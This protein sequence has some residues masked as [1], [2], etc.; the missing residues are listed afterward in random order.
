MGRYVPIT[1]HVERCI[2][3]RTHVHTHSQI[4]HLVELSFPIPESTVAGVLNVFAQLGGIAL[5]YGLEYL[6][7]D[8]GATCGNFLLAGAMVGAGLC[9]LCTTNL[10]KRQELKENA[11]IEATGGTS[12]PT[13]GT[14]LRKDV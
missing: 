1:P 5:I 9:Y 2:L 11:A 12:E 6:V 3:T 4:P 13:E 7:A 14:P 10:L 8:L